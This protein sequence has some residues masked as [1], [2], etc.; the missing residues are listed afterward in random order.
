MR[1]HRLLH[2]LAVNGLA[3]TVAGIVAAAGLLLLNVGGL[4]TLVAGAE[5][6][7]LPV[8]LMTFGFVVTLAS[9]AMGSAIMRIG[10]DG[11]DR[12]EGRLI[13]IRIET[14]EELARRRRRMR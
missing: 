14:D 1:R 11:E 6:P 8:A 7:I 12:P 3:G 4:G 13:P 9:V 5:E 2:L 10:Q